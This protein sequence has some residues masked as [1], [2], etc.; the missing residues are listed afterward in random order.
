M[1]DY[2]STLGRYLG[3]EDARTAIVRVILQD[4]WNKYWIKH[5]EETES[6]SYQTGEKLSDVYSK[7][8]IWGDDVNLRIY[9]HCNPTGLPLF[10]DENKE[11]A[12]MSF[13]VQNGFMSIGVNLEKKSGKKRVKSY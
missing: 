7:A 8:M 12:G 11:T 4:D 13:R 6:I 1:D 3:R 9:N 10:N 5:A 2:F